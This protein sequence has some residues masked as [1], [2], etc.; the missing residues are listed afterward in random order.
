M[1]LAHISAFMKMKQCKNKQI[2]LFVTDE[3]V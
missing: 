2:K 3:K 1:S